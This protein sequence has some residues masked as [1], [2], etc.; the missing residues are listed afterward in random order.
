MSVLKN[1]FI[2]F[3]LFS[4]ITLYPESGYSQ[5]ISIHLR[6]V[7]ESKISL[8]PL[9]GKDALKPLIIVDS[10]KN[11]ATAKLNVP[12]EYLPGEFVLRFDYKEKPTSTPYP[13]EK[14]IIISDQDL[15]L[16]VHPIYCNNTDSTWFQDNEREN[17]TY[18][19]F[20][21]ENSVKVRVLGLLQ[22]F[23]LNY[24]DNSSKF[25]V[26]GIKEYK[27]R[28]TIYNQWISTMSEEYKDM[29]V[30]NLFGFNHIPMINW[31]GSEADRKQSLRD[32]YF[33]GMDF[34]KPLI[35]KTSKMKEWMD[36]YV[37]L[38]GELATNIILRDS[39][40]THAG[41][42]AIEKARQG[43]SEVYGWMVDYF[44]NGFE[45]FNIEEG[46]K[47]LE[48]YLND[49]DCLTTKRQK[50]I[51]RLNGIK[52]LVPGTTAPNIIM[53]DAENRPFELY[54][55]QTEKKYLLILFWSGDCGHC[56]ET[57]GQLY[58]WSQRADIQQG[59]DVMAISLDETD[60]EIESWQQKIRGLKGWNHL[61]AKEGVRS[62]AANDYSI[63][64]IP[65]MFLLNAKTREI[66]G[67]PENIKEMEGLMLL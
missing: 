41:K 11:G 51:K 28:W 62:K 45:S 31:R 3:L 54:T 64:S 23:L 48:P 7:Y 67:L 13:S 53:N 4:Y 57:I 65:V 61:P 47:M 32:N 33:E 38:Y 42:K 17:N 20:L 1:I 25:Y 22:G 14:R 10:I 56:I 9:V 60:I 44:F 63:L 26:K 5:E 40:F 15:E 35:L 50:I 37:N 58:P 6:G 19:W 49:P 30:S 12:D 52:T 39:L 43:H 46:I 55:Y 21:Q 2:T 59:L 66:I 18:S 34:T 29:Y 8:L 27:K 36:A 24:D 16:W